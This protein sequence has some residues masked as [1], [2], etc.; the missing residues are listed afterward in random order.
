MKNKIKLTVTKHSYQLAKRIAEINYRYCD[1]QVKHL[2]AIEIQDQFRQ[3]ERELH[4]NM[5]TYLLKRKKR[6]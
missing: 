5:F 2:I 6:L 1:A 3:L 4:M